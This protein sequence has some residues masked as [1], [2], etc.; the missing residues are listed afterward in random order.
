MSVPKGTETEVDTDEEVSWRTSSYTGTSGQCVEV[1]L[2]AKRVGI[3]DSKARDLGEFW[4]P[5]ASFDALQ[6]VLVP[7]RKKRG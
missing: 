5:R 4:I 7:H 1:A 2:G 6:D 3:R